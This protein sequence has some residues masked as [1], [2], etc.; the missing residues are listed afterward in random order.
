MGVEGGGAGLCTTP[1]H[2]SPSLP[3][4]SPALWITWLSHLLECDSVSLFP[5]QWGSHQ[6]MPSGTHPSVCSAHFCS[7]C[8]CLYPTLKETGAQLM[9]AVMCPPSPP[10][11]PA[12]PRLCDWGK[13]SVFTLGG[14]LYFLKL[15]RWRSRATSSKRWTWDWHQSGT[16]CTGR[17]TLQN[18]WVRLKRRQVHVLH[19]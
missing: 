10:F 14:N 19:T 11:S 9:R 6:V 7:G 16:K 2:S 4:C 13:L 12:L 3:K 15:Q 18:S 1:H 5:S 8:E 17:W